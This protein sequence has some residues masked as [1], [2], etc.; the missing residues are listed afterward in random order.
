MFLQGTAEMSSKVLNVIAIELAILIGILGWFAFTNKRAIS[1]PVQASP[2]MVDSFAT[3]APVR[4]KAQ[5]YQLPVDYRADAAPEPQPEEEVAQVVQEYDS[6]E[7]LEEDETLISN[8]PDDTA[9]DATS[10]E[11]AVF[12]PEPEA[13]SADPPL[14]PVDRFIVY[15]Q[16][17]AVIVITNPRNR[18]CRPTPSRPQA[19][20]GPRRGHRP[21]PRSQ[22]PRQSG[23]DM[24]PRPKPRPQTARL[25]VRPKLQQNP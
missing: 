13:G 2:P 15:P 16:S 1:A 7:L 6:P 19:S 9:I 11:Y 17:T 25:V 10:P 21:P 8:V 23:R 22:P 18:S 5:R 3:V 4:R 20:P 14:A 24:A 12:D